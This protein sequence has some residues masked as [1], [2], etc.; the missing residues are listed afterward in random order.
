MF[1]DKTV[2]FCMIRVTIAESQISFGRNRE[3]IM[4]ISEQQNRHV[5]RILPLVVWV[6]SLSL[7]VHAA[8]ATPKIG[9]GTC[10]NSTVNGTYFYLLSGSVAS[11]GQV[12]PYS[13]L[14][15]LVADGQGGVQG[16]SYGSVIG[17]QY[18]YSLNGTYSIQPSCAGTM[19]LTVHSQTSTSNSTS[20]STYQNTVAFQV[21]NNGLGMTLA[22]YTSSA[23]V[24]G[25][26]DRQTA[27]ATPI[28]C[29]TGS[30]SGGYGYVLA[31]ATAVSGGT[32][33]Y[34]DAG[35][36]T[37]DG[38]G[39]LSGASL[40]NL[41][42][43]VSQVTG[44]GTYTVGSDCS[45]TASLIGSQNT[46]ANY[47]F[48]LVR[49]G[50]VALVFGSDPGRIVSGVFTPQFAPPQNSVVNGASFRS[51]MVSPGS[52]FSIF[53]TGLSAH[54]MS[55][56]T[57][58][59]PNLLGGTQVLV[60]GTPAP[61]LYVGDNQVNAQMPI[62]VPPGQAVTFTVMNGSTPSNSVTLTLPAA[63]P[64]F[65]T[66]NGKDAIVQ[67][68]NGSMNS[69]VT[70]AHPGDVLVAYLTGGGAVNAAGPW[71]TGAD[72]PQGASSV[73]ASYSL[74]IGGQ[75]A[76]VQ[77]VG[78]APGFVGLYQANFKLPS[79][80]AGSY[81]MVLTIGGVS[82]NAASVVVGD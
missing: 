21:V 65:F 39:N 3:G 70:P 74:T 58:P 20:T 29:G 30:M 49:D 54:P 73:Q 11:G 60:N 53:G 68:P 9:G 46:S 51:Q 57:V 4:Q 10:S 12:G 24:A 32:S 47:R 72:S 50:Q 76:D 64:G 18:T 75:P 13:E 67:N 44:T 61:L 25:E 22:I 81:P 55:A 31:G 41:G 36:I 8:A 59:L 33:V 77:Y 38:N 79:L 71:V 82:S 19:T 15:K 1:G 80:A 16:S 17:Q 69:A 23:V 43:A 45:G 66:S 62:D 42:G 37:S 48:A 2:D 26:A 5:V 63:A 34:S 14:G 56:G 27:S 7:C 78:L 52:L 35:Q 6:A 28:Q 40:A